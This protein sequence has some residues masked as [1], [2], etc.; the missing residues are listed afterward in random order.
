MAIVLEVQPYCS[1]CLDFDADVTRPGKM[2]YPDGE[3]ILGDTYVKCRYAKRCE[4]IRKYLIRQDK[5]N[6]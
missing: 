4:N 2:E 3:I 1:H 6:V 5:E